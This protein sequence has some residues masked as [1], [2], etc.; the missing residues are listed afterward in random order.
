MK[1]IISLLLAVSIVF[2][3][4]AGISVMSSA[5]TA[6]TRNEAVNWAN[7]Q[8]GKSLDYDNVNGAQCVDLIKYYY[9]YLGVPTQTGNASAYATNTPPTGWKK[10]AYYN[11]FV[12]QPGDIAVWTYLSSSAGHIGIVTSA[13]TSGM[14]LVDQNGFTKPAHIVKTCW[15][16]Y[17]SGTFYGV[18]R[19]DFDIYFNQTNVLINTYN[20]IQ[21][22]FSVSNPKNTKVTGFKTQIRKAG[23]ANWSSYKA[24]FTST[25]SFTKT[26]T[27]ASNGG[28]KYSVCDGTTYEIRGLVLTASKIYYSDIITVTTPARIGISNAQLSGTGSVK[29]TGSNISVN[30]LINLYYNGKKLTKGTDFKL[31]KDNV[32]SIGKHSITITGIGAFKG[33]RTIRITIYPKTPTLNSL[34]YSSFTGRI[35]LKWARVADCSKQQIAMSKSSSF[36]SSKSTLF[37]V[38]S[39]KQSCSIYSYTMNGKSEHIEKGKTY[40]FKMRAYKI[41]DGEKIYGKWGAVKSIKCK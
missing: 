36:T 20:K 5:Y 31:S 1:K 17:Y 38:G 34:S 8:V 37:T 39:E 23:N 16:D 33:S 10:I 14:N 11:G 6:H 13:N 35:S 22:K 41:V 12:A 32:K 24:T 2:G 28:C 30:N 29:Y 21:V 19:P 40:Y 25:S 27:I 9:N 18:I 26:S 7:D 3:L 15:R 4:F